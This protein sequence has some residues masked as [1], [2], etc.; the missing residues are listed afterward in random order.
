MRQ[1]REVA[2]RFSEVVEPA[3]MRQQREV[4]KRFSEVVEPA[5]M[6][7][8]REVAK[9]FSEV[10]DLER[11]AHLGEAIAQGLGEH[12]DDVVR[13]GTDLIDQVDRSL[14]EHLHEGSGHEEGGLQWDSTDTE[15]LYWSLAVT[16]AI[17]LQASQHLPAEVRG[18]VTTLVGFLEILALLNIFRPRD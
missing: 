3:F 18:P 1:Q 15:I 16:L 11:L 13:L 4:A 17:T 5:F 7:Q 14:P 6:R 8:Q 9:R 2:K 12:A 10:V